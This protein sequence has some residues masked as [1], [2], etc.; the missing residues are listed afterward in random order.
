MPP[1]ALVLLFSEVQLAALKAAGL[2]GSP[3]PHAG[4]I[5]Q[6]IS[7]LTSNWEWLVGTGLGLVLVLLGGLLAF[8]SIQAPGW[9]FKVLAG[10]LVILVGAPAVLA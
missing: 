9:F 10:I 2:N 1:A 8:G 7:T 3:P 5:R 4:P 6:L